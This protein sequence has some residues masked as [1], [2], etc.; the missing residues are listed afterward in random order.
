[1]YSYVEMMFYIVLSGFGF[2]TLGATLMYEYMRRSKL[3]M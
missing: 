3:K 2:F 1:M